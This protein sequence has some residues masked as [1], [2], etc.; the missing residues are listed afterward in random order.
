MKNKLHGLFPILLTPY[1][2]NYN[3]DLQSLRKLVDYYLDSGVDGLTCL[4]E[5]SETEML[6]D[7]ERSTV[8]RTIISE[9]NGRVPIVTG[10][11][12]AS[13]KLTIVSMQDAFSM[14]SSAVLVPPPKN[15]RM[16]ASSIVDYY[17]DL[18]SMAPCPVTILD[19]PSLGFPTI[20]SDA[21]AS[22]VRKSK[23]V[24][25]IKVED[26]PSNRKISSLRKLL[27]SDVTIYSATHGRNI[28]WDLEQGIDGI[29][30]SAPFPLQLR[31]VVDLYNRG[32]K[33]EAFD[34][35]TLTLPL[36]YYMQE[37]SVAVKKEIL[38]HIGVIPNNLVRKPVPQIDD[39]AIA[40]LDNLVDWTLQKIGVIPT[41]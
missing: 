3:V 18:D 14:G 16:S 7:E 13:L 4:G 22:I 30:T 38:H 28:Y 8:M 23:H 17:L 9:V 11:G 24:K 10:V 20:P 19:N 40:E 5:V 34:L 37:Y 12:R 31:K 6:G 2:S 39:W 1:D 15:I 21:V 36:G 35:F 25:A 32:K 26:Q 33:N 29:M 41:P 27:G